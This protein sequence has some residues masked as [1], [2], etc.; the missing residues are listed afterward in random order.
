MQQEEVIVSSHLKWKEKKLKLVKEK[1]DKW[2]Q[3]ELAAK[4]GMNGKFRSVREC[5]RV[6]NVAYRTLHKG[7]VTN[8]GLFKGSGKFSTILSREEEMLVKEHFLYMAKIG[9]GLLITSVRHLV[10]DLLMGAL[11][12]NPNRVTGLETC[13][14]MPSISWVTRFC[15]RHELSLRRSSV[16][17]KGHAVVLPS[18]LLRW[19]QDIDTFLGTRTDLKEAM[20]NPNGCLI[21]MK[22]QW[23]L[24]L[25]YKRFWLLYPRSKF[26][27]SQAQPMIMYH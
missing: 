3:L 1:E 4:D 9:Y 10:H 7:I 15:D 12:A 18:D 17:S 6:H 22:Q 25:G 23:N 14:Q 16:I 21:L 13:N 20:A 19:F 24:V 11:Q 26:I 5:A 8:A 27:L 2:K